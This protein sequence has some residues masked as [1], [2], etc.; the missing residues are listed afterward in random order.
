LEVNI[1]TTS[2]HMHADGRSIKQMLMNLLSNAVKFTPETGVIGLSVTQDKPGEA[3][4]F[5]VWDTGIGIDIEEQKRLFQPFVQVDSRLSR[6]HEGTGLGLALVH[7]MAK[8]HGGTVSLESEPGKGSRFTI[9]LPAHI[10][11]VESTR[12]AFWTTNT[13]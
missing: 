2:T 13:F 8:L 3:I 12:P 10:D 4:H 5:T 1:D 11:H 7:K 6:A 9:T